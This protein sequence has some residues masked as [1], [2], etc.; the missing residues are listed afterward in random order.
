MGFFN[1]SIQ[2]TASSWA[3][4]MEEDLN[5]Y[6]GMSI[7]E[8]NYAAI[9]ETEMNW[10]AIMETAAMN[11]IQY[12]AENGE[13]YVYTEAS[14]F[15]AAIAEFFK[16][17]WEKIKAIFK[18]FMVMLGS[19]TMKDKDFV[20]K[21][22][23][24]IRKGVANLATDGVTIKGFKFN[25][26]L[27]TTITANKND[28]IT[29]YITGDNASKLAGD[30]YDSAEIME[31]QRAKLA[32]VSGTLTESEF[33][34]ELFEMLRGGESS[35]EDI[36]V[37]S[38]MVFE[39]LGELENSKET[40]KSAEK[41]YAN[42]EKVFKAVIKDAEKT[43]KDLYSTA[44]NNEVNG[45][46]DKENARGAKAI[47]L[48]RAISITKSTATAFQTLC[49]INLQAVKDYYMQQKKICVKAVTGKRA[50]KE[51]AFVEHV[52]EGNIFGNVNLI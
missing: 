10:N 25:K 39:A 12:F 16:K 45:D 34:K 40:R 24:A 26:N 19:V 41:A 6:D 35:P 52:A 4:L 29:Y 50:T 31:E 18:K 30:D 47:N 44:K 3:G 14:G 17:I 1:T 38:N 48:N 33:R 49:S 42:A 9:A 8:A 15:G 43:E 27:F 51:G 23:D 28:V 46:V 5:I 21:H 37:T 13:E 7:M 32:G 2:N 11:E 36:D 22:G 20:K